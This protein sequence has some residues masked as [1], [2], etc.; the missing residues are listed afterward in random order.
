MEQI[1]MQML[2]IVGENLPMVVGDVLELFG[3]QGELFL[4]HLQLLRIFYLKD[5]LLFLIGLLL[6]VVLQQIIKVFYQLTEVLNPW[7]F[8]LIGQQ[9]EKLI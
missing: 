4:P 8:Q 3:E 1:L 6:F 9:R 2:L 5:L 7:E